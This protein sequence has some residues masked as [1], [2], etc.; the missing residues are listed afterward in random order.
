MIAFFPPHEELNKVPSFG[1]DPL[2]DCLV[3]DALPEF[4]EHSKGDK[5]RGNFL[6]DLCF[7]PRTNCVVLESLFVSFR[8]LSSLRHV[9]CVTSKAVAV[10]GVELQQRT[11][12]Y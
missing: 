8:C 4:N 10:Q 3:R 12:A 5:L 11:I 2:V 9:M 6:S 7:H 1:V